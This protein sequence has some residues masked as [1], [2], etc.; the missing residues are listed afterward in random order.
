M[1]RMCQVE[2]EGFPKLLIACNS[3]VKD[4][5]EV[6]IDDDEVRAAQEGMMEFLLINHP[7]DCPICDQ[8]G[9]CGLQD[10]SFKHGQAFSRFSYEDKRT[11]PGNERSGCTGCSGSC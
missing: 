2:V 5:M 7:L 9:E 3:Q 8:A 4:G 11:Y 1:C 6:R 10:Y